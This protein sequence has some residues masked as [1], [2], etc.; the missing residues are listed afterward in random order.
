MKKLKILFSVIMIFSLFMSCKKSG[1][2]T[3]DKTT[4]KQGEVITVTNT[5]K[6]ASKYYKWDFGGVE[7]VDLNPVYTLP[8]TTPVGSFTIS[9]LPVNSLNTTDNWKKGSK[10]VSVEEAEE[11]KFLFYLSQPVLSASDEVCIIT[12][13]GMSKTISVNSIAPSCESNNNLHAATFDNLKSGDYNYTINGSSSSGSYSFSGVLE[14]E[15][16]FDCRIIDVYDL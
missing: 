15:D 13:E 2:F 4:Y 6:K 8:K 10:T 9:I 11:A 5:T 3:T 16:G 12:I 14:L 1:D 7:I